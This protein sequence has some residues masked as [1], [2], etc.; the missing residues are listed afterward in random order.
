MSLV[1]QDRVPAD[2]LKA[3]QQ[4]AKVLGIQAFTQARGVDHVAEQ[5]GQLPA[6]ALGQG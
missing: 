6:F 2:A 1:T 3:M 5:H 4:I